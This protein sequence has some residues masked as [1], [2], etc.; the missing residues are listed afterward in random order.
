MRPVE[1]IPLHVS[2][3]ANGISVL[4]L[5]GRRALGE[6]RPAPSELVSLVRGGLG[7]EV[8]MRPVQLASSDGSVSVGHRSRGNPDRLIILYQFTRSGR[9]IP[10]LTFPDPVMRSC[11][12]GMVM[13]ASRTGKTRV[14]PP[15]PSLRPHFCVACVNNESNCLEPLPRDAREL[16]GRRWRMSYVLFD[17]YFAVKREACWPVTRFRKVMLPG[18]C[19]DGLGAHQTGEQSSRTKAFMSLWQNKDVPLHDHFLHFVVLDR[20]VEYIRHSIVV[21]L[22]SGH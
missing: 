17:G 15:A 22:Y 14:L 6:E 10:R 20:A 3:I 21:V 9:R 2:N 19:D 11:C 5:R 16:A 13:Q 18:P 1:V 8:G 12:D 4:D 7:G